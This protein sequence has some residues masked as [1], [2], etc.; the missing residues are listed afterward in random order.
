MAR[1]RPS[2]GAPCSCAATTTSAVIN[3]REEQRKHNEEAEAE[4]QGT[5]TEATEAKAATAKQPALLYREPDMAVRA[6]REEFNSTYRGVVLDDE[7]FV[8]RLGG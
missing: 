7:D 5:A 1:A 8:E 2:G 6:I 3:A 4:E